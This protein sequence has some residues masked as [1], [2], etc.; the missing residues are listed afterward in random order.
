M[1][2]GDPLPRL[3]I[4]GLSSERHLEISRHLVQNWL[5]ALLT[6]FFAQA[7]P[8]AHKRFQSA[9]HFDYVV[10]QDWL[11]LHSRVAIANF[12]MG[13][14]TLIISD[15][16]VQHLLVHSQALLQPLNPINFVVE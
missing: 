1:Q 14:E 10:G 3:T 7:G 5:V 6:F 16:Q 15:N 12:V 4:V 11:V 9:P 13:E 2:H 8:L